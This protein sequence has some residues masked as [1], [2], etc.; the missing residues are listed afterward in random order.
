MVRGD[1]LDYFGLA[2]YTD[3]ELKRMGYTVW[4]P[5]QA[6]GSWL[7]EGDNH[8][9][10]NLLGNGLRAYEA[11]WYGGWGGRVPRQAS[12]N[13]PFSALTSPDTSASAMA[14][15]LRTVN[16]QMGQNTE[17]MVYPNFFP[18]AQNSFAARLKW[19]VTPRYADANHE[20]VVRIMGPLTVAAVAGQPIKLYGAVSDPDGNAVSVRWWI[21]PMESYPH[22]VAITN[23]DS[24][25][26]DV[27]IPQ[28]VKAGQTIHLILEAT[29]N[30]TPSLTKYQRVIVMIK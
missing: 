6:K 5:V 22:R 20:P 13:S 16:T 14:T 25:Q 2:G 3:K 28:D 18:P 17:Q 21:F 12:T 19:S 24:L 15:G 29:D 4:L 26:P 7:G 11:G 23:P 30:G 27:L 1:R 10:M 9:F 8:T